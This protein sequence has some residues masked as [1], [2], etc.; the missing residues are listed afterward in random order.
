MLGLVVRGYLGHSGHASNQEHLSYV[1]LGHL[2]ILHG[3]LTWGHGAADQVSHDAFK[4]STT[5]LHVEMFRPRS[6]HGQVGEV[7]VSLKRGK[8]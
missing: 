1:S 3:F 2:G 8:T 6:I 7:D 4:L 5:Q